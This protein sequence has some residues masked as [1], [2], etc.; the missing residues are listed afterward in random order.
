MTTTITLTDDQYSQVVE[1]MDKQI[2]MLS[3]EEIEAIASRLNEKI[4]IPFFSDGREKTIFVK[5]TKKVDRLLYRHLPNEI[6]GCV[7]SIS[8]GI[9]DKDAEQIKSVMGSRLNKDFNI[10]YLPEW[11]ELQ[12]FEMLVGLLVGAMRQNY[13]ALELPES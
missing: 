3:K 10:P 7:K 6:Y 11:V 9:S 1:D 2:E 13:S 4:D 12:I 5:I 8:D